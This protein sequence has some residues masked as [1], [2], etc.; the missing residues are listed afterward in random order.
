[1][2]H[3]N[4]RIFSFLIMTALVL[5]CAP[6]LVPESAPV[7]TFDP[8]SINTAIGLTAEAAA[9]QTALM[10]PPTLT[11]TVTMFPSNT[12]P[13][14]ETPTPTFLFIL[15]TPTV[16]SST[17]T[18]EVSGSQYACR[19][20]SQTPADNSTFAQGAN[21]DAH[22][23]VT[24]I[25]TDAWD[26]DS[27][28]YRFSNGDRIHKASIYDFS[29]SVAPGKQTEIVVDMKAPD[30]AGTYTTTWK[31]NIGKNKFCSMNLTIIVN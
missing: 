26:S 13:P 7:P 5:A 12:P 22:W 19:V 20:N 28:D 10:I 21:F 27:A 18:L 15:S 31:I 2:L 8:N 3:R 16:P 29:K 25:G 30:S 23:V 24:N 14:S 17:P 4:Y 9:T 6:T 11:P 1:M